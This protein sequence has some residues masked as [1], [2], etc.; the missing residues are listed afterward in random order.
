MFLEQILY[1]ENKFFSFIHGRKV[2]ILFS[3]AIKN[4][5]LFNPTYLQQILRQPTSLKRTHLQLQQ[6]L[7][8]H[9]V[10]YQHITL[11]SKVYPCIDVFSMRFLQFSL[12]SFILKYFNKFYGISNPFFLEN[13]INE[14]LKVSFNLVGLAS[15][16]NELNIFLVEYGSKSSVP[17]G[18][19]F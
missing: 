13:Q 16:R 10:K 19:F 5:S 18:N 12:K 9:L 4:N 6:H 2:D 3:I 11:N 14:N 8:L 15:K 1:K 17:S 7:L